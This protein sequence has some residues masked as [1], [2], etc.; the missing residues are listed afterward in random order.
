MKEYTNEQISSLIDSHIHNKRDRDLLKRRLVDG[1][2]YEQLASEFELS[3]QR[4]K[5]IVYKSMQKLI[6]YL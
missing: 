5:A 1:I 3:T 4:V 6:K 2:V